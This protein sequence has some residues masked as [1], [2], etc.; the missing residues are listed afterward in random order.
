MVAY[1]NELVSKTYKKI[2]N[3]HRFKLYLIQILPIS[4][5]DIITYSILL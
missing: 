1:V 2:Y 4:K 5:Y 3:I